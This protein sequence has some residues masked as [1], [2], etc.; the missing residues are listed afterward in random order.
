MIAAVTRDRSLATRRSLVDGL[1]NWRDRSRWQD[2]HRIYSR[3]IYGFARRAG[4]TDAEAHDALQ[5]TMLTV[6]RRAEGFQY[7]PARGSFKGWLLQIARWRVADQL[8]K[9]LPEK[10]H[11]PRDAATARTATIARAVDP[12]GPELEAVWNSEWHASLL[13]A[14]LDRIKRKVSPRQ[15]QIFDCYVVK[16]WPVQRV[17]R[18]LGVNR[19]QVYLAKHRVAALL[20]KELEALQA[21]PAFRGK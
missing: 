7:D 3:L 11:A 21:T 5:E 9:R 2:F 8:R 16:E 14:A 18:D 19:A 13:D 1:A 17:Q 15:Y 20:R 12:A 4:L 6:A 10:P